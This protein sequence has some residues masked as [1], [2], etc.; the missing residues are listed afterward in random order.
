M[1]ILVEIFGLIIILI[2]IGL[3][4]QNIQNLNLKKVNTVDQKNLNKFP[5]IRHRLL[6][7]QNSNISISN[8]KRRDRQNK[9]VNLP[10]HW[11]KNPF[12]FQTY[13]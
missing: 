8:V 11:D 12:L 10:N 1:R 9:I 3:S 5:H 2:E 6:V 7:S 4:W 13:K